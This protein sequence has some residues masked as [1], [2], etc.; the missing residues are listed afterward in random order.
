MNAKQQALK[1]AMEAAEKKAK[2]LWSEFTTAREE[3]TTKGTI[4]E[5]KVFSNL[6]ALKQAYEE[7]AEETVKARSAFMASLDGSGGGD[8]LGTK[9]RLFGDWPSGLSESFIE[10]AG[11][12]AFDV[13]S[14]GTA[15]SPFYDPAIRSLPQRRLFVRSLIPVKAIPNEKFDFLR[16]TVATFNAAETA[17]GSA[18]PTSVLSLERVEDRVRTIAHLSEPVDRSFLLDVDNLRDFIDGQLRLGVLLREDAQVVAGNG[19][20]E[21]L[22]GILNTSGILTQAKGADPTVDTVLKAS[23]KLQAQANPFV[24]NGL[25]LHPNDLQDV[26]LMRDANG[27][28]QAAD[29]GAVRV[30]E[31]GRVFLWGL[32][33]ISTIAITEGT[34]LVGD[35]N[36]ATIYDR[37][38]ARVDWFESGGLGTAGAEIA[39]RNQLVARG[40]ERIGFAV[41]RPSAFCSLTGI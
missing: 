9:E 7:S 38:Q 20:G 27:N 33:V 29:S 16:Q 26:L 25:V 14:G 30:T 12:K 41:H 1:T 37:E 3:A 17:A 39:S 24:A 22:R 18:K 32:E 34:G 28:Y 13:T 35:F 5:D 15:T 40:E 23:V 2:G 4:S 6:T 21:N 8:T 10:S 19:T 11:T 36:Q 31:D